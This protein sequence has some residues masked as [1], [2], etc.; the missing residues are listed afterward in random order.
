MWL[1]RMIRFR[2]LYLSTARSEAFRLKPPKAAANV[3]RRSHYEEGPEIEAASPYEVWSRLRGP[4]EGGRADA[5]KP[6]NVGDALEA[7]DRLVVCNY[8]GFD[9]AEWRAAKHAAANNRGESGEDGKAAQPLRDR[10]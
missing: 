2:V 1:G 3:L 5:P 7:G 10:A 6:L 9:P 8:W 4:S